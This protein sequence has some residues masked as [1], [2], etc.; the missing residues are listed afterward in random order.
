MKLRK[1]SA[2]NNLQRAPGKIHYGWIVIF[3]GTLTT[4][5]AHGF[6]RMAYTLILPEMSAGL[7]ITN[8]GAGMLA[9]GKLMGYLVFAL[10][11]GVLASI[12]GSRVVISSPL[13]MGITMGTTGMAASFEFALVMR[14]LT[15]MKRRS[16]CSC[17]G[18]GFN[19]VCHE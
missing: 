7:G 9:S 12:Y 6:G 15:G 13:L 17:D 18:P 1:V 14:L 5:G 19:L 10:V 8:T 11:G 2:L 4:I 16:V 3:M